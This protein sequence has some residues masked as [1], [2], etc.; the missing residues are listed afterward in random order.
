[1]HSVPRFVLQFDASE[2]G[3]Y[4]ARF[5]SAGDSEV[6]AMARAAGERGY[7]TLP[8]FRAVCRWKTPRSGPFV[9]RNHPE[10]VEART[11]LALREQTTEHDR[12]RALRQLLGVEWATA[13]VL[14]HLVCPDR[15]PILDVRALHA[16]GIRGRQTYSYRFW[17]DYVNAFRALVARS[18][19]DG[20]TVDR[21]LWQWSA[22]QGE[23]LA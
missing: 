8:E 11:A 23:P 18:G 1:L 20:R 5:P 14:L 13:S 10:D 4:A 15:Y 3:G 19:L 7:Y 2:I 17:L 22:E 6:L 9:A 12:M 16:F 21:G